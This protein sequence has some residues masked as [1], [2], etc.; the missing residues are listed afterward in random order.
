ML[1]KETTWNIILELLY[2]TIKQ[3]FPHISKT[4]V[5]EMIKCDKQKAN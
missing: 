3:N 4:K 2:K 5:K 1:V